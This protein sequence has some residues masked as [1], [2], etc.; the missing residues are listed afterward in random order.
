MRAGLS[1]VAAAAAALGVA[2]LVAV[3]TGPL[4]A[5]LLAVGGVVVDSVPPPVKDFGVAVFGVHDKT[6]LITGTAVLLAGYAWLVG[7]V[8]LR[9]WRLALGGVALFGVIG[10][11]AAVTRHDAGVSAALPSLIGALIAV[12]V[13]NY[14]LTLS[15][16][17]EPRTKSAPA[18]A[19]TP[20]A[21]AVDERPPIVGRD[22]GA[23]AQT[24]QD[25][26]AAVQTRQDGGAAAQTRQDGAAVQTRQD[27]GAAATL[28]RRVAR[29]RRPA[30]RVA[31]RCIGSPAGP[32]TGSVTRAGLW[33][34]RAASVTRSIR[35][36]AAGGFSR[37]WA[38][39]PPWPWSAASPVGCSPARAVSAA[40][41]SVVLPPPGRRRRLS[42][43]TPRSA[44][45]VAYVTS[46]PDFYRIDT[47]LYPP[48]VDP[49]SWALQ[50]PRHGAQ[51]DHA[52][53]GQLLAAA[54]GRAVRD[55]GLRLQRGR[56]R[57]DRQRALARHADQGPAR[58]GRPAAGCRPGR[59]A[60]RSTAGP[61]A[62][63]PR[64]CATAATRCSPSA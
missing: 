38:S 49:A 17:S 41:N 7:A 32:A 35:R 30:R 64:C 14:L 46:N 52:H 25:G 12:P 27:G 34:P 16:G 62:R 50:D 56:R 51:P 57:P 47:P 1:G 8:A 59:A 33:I 3:W 13:L 10:A 54:D 61:A 39:W 6:A 18:L 5:P 11:A 2:E 22:R 4:S 28:A 20:A 63:R 37:R 26:G 31:R 9:S 55:A 19:E 44:G 60:G 48:Q 15:L 43:P 23:A 53:L 36:R 29:R 45:R 42:R 21:V 24:R 40:R 58:R